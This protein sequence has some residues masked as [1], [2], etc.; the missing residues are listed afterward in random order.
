MAVPQACTAA[1]LGCGS[2]RLATGVGPQEIVGP[3]V[4][5]TG[6]VLLSCLVVVNKKMFLKVETGNLSSVNSREIRRKGSTIRITVD[7]D[8]WMVQLILKFKSTT[9]LDSS[10]FALFIVSNL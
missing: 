1:R 4:H 2:G 8:G 10:F 3:H 9:C 5:S 7:V 6:V